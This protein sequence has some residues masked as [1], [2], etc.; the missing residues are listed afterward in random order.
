MKPPLPRRGENSLGAKDGTV[1]TA[2]KGCQRSGKLFLS[3]GT[4]RLG[5]EARE[6]LV[7]IVVMMLVA[8]ALLTVVMMMRMAMALLI[9][10]VMMLVAMALLT[11]VMMMLMTVALLTVVMM[12]LM[13]V[14]LLIIVVMMLMAMAL[15]TVVMVVMMRLLHQLGKNGRKGIG[16]GG[17]REDLAAGNRLPGRRDDHG[18]LVPFAEESDRGGH[19]LLGHIPGAR[20][21]DG[22]GVLHLVVEEFAEVFHIHTALLSIHHHGGTAKLGLGKIEVADGTNDVAELADARRLNKNAVGGVVGDHLTERPSKITDEATADAAGV[23]FVDGDPRLAEKATVDPDLTELIFNEND[24]LTGIRLG[25][26]LFDQ[27]SL[28]RAEKAGID[29]NFCHGNTHSSFLRSSS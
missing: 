1:F 2:I 4:C 21:D 25:N 23:H 12:M 28:P 13:T 3:E 26:Q 29:I 8:M 22:T 17:G 5:P 20:K 19:R 11:V 9:I 7:G 6:H 14:A 24:S 15:L 10:V 18:A 16:A 27:G